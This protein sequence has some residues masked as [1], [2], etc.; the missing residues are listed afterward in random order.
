MICVWSPLQPVRTP[1]HADARENVPDTFS[2]LSS[3][4][5]AN[6][7]EGYLSVDGELFIDVTSQEG[8]EQASVC[9]KGLTV[10]SSGGVPPASQN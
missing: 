8:C 10:P 4:A 6:A 9:I 3:Q 2:S 5:T 1:V 7:G